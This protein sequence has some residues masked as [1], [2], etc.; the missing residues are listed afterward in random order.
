MY[1]IIANKSYCTGV[2][3]TH[4][5]AA[6]CATIP[7]SL[8]FWSLLGL[9]QA[10]FLMHRYFFYCKVNVK[11]NCAK[12][13]SK[14]TSVKHYSGGNSTIIPVRMLLYRNNCS[15]AEMGQGER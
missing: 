7:F 14:Y 9:E 5:S 1:T 4:N 10:A 6:Y 13:V 15:P 8:C 12:V 11:D 2:V 3:T